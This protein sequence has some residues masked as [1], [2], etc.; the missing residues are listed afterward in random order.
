VAIRYSKSFAFRH[1]TRHS[2]ANETITPSPTLQMVRRKIHCDAKQRGLNGANGVTP[3]TALVSI[4]F[5][6][7]ATNALFYITGQWKSS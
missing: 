6:T 5:P 7:C 1:A 3:Q 2:V 4:P